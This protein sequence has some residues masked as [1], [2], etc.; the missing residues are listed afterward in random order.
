MKTQSKLRLVLSLS[1]AFVSVA[2]MSSA[3]AQR[4]DNRRLVWTGSNGMEWSDASW[5]TSGSY[6]AYANADTNSPVWIAADALDNASFLAGDVAIF[7]S[8]GDYHP[9]G[10]ATPR[11]IDI[12][13][14][15]VTASEVIVSGGGS[16]VFTGGAIVADGS[17][18]APGST[19]ITGTGSG[20]AST[21]VSPAGRL[22]K[23]NTGNLTLSNTVANVFKGGIYLGA[24]S[25]TIADKNALGDNNITVFATAATGNIIMP[26]IVTGA[27]GALLRASTALMTPVTISVPASADG[28]HITGD[29]FI[30]AGALTLNIEGETTI[31]GRL[32]GRSTQFGADRGS[33]YKTGSGTLILTG[34]N[35]WFYNSG[36]GVDIP[37]RIEA[38]RLVATTPYAIGTGAWRI[39]PGAVLEF[40]GVNGTLKQAFIDGGNIEITQGSDVTFHWRAGPLDDYESLGTASSQP[41]SSALGGIDVSGA[42]RFTAIATG[43][44]ATVLGGGS[45]QVFIRENST[46]VLGRE[47]ISSRGTA[48][49]EIPMTYPILA[50]RLSLTDASTLILN[51]NAY[52][53]TGALTISED[54]I[55]SFG[56]SGVSRIRWQDGIT[57]A[58]LEDENH[59]RYRTPEGMKL[60]INELDADTGYYREYVVVNQGANPLK[61]IAITLN[62]LDALHDTL[63]ARLAEE[64]I[65]PIL[66][67]TPSRGRKWTN[68]AWARYIVS[69]VD[70]DAVS[71]TTPG[72][73]GRIAGGVMG[74]DFTLP[75]RV[76]LGVHAGAI[77]NDLSTTNSTSLA[78][79]QKLLGVHAA[80]RSGKFYLAAAI[81][82]GRARTDSQRNEPASLVRGKWD[83]SYYSG[84]VEVGATFTPLKKTTLRPYAGLRYSKIKIS[85]YYE[86]GASPLMVEDFSDTG[87]HVAYGVVAG[88]KFTL[89]KRDIG[90]DLTLARKHTVTAPRPTLDTYYYD[91]PDTLITLERGDYYSDITAAGLS[92]RAAVTK[93][94]LAG[95]AYDYETASTHT[96]FA[97]SAMVGY[98]W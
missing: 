55:I 90:I 21:N 43:T 74:F 50:T 92:L 53:N 97:V 30:D 67:H 88:R 29:I 18:V 13:G 35:N 94:T 52:L 10:D 98:S 28:L 36:T 76:L 45:S 19:Q 15:G 85:G 87:T 91:S 8:A 1:C 11:V 86:R 54:S 93:H 23:I 80:Q 6:L 17:S 51:P 33:V 96:R 40:R 26:A 64:F 34:A 72:V 3:A 16:Y 61:D 83:T 77:Q 20:M 31:S 41:A 57:P 22:I 46:L 66:P 39:Y 37:N 27:N 47:G 49:T 84:S 75:G 69:Q 71:I 79:K 12:A 7:D 63:N 2:F 56:A 62:A 68:D 9:S 73:T 38:G 32:Y 82:L 44:N 5:K 95:L 4:T 24:G 58:E 59:Y 25:L 81:D 70:Y 42:S 65:D 89:F 60:T 48:S 14:A 78:S